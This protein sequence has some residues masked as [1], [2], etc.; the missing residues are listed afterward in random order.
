MGNHYS[1]GMPSHFS[2]IGLAVAD[3]SELASVMDSVIPAAT[4][5]ALTRRGRHLQWIDPAGTSI[6]FHLDR[7]G[8]IEC[9]T[10]FFVPAAGLARWRVRT[11][12]PSPD[13]EC[14]HCSGADCDVL[15]ADGQMVTRTAVQ[16]ACFAPYEEW[17]AHERTYD[18]EV[19]AFAERAAFFASEAEFDAAQAE[20]WGGPKGSEKKPLRFAPVSFLPEGLFGAAKDMDQRAISSFAGR[21]ERAET[22][23]PE[24][25]KAFAHVRISTLP[26][27]VDVVADPAIFEG[28]PEVGRIAWIRA[29]LVGRPVEPAP[30]APPPRSWWGRLT[31]R[32]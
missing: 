29:W 23:K 1:P 26:G 4:E 21:V 32:R 16:W 25:G 24:R 31:G 22:S 7:A 19:V 6:C 17:L 3:S 8:R 20:W 28:A 10:P 2:S 18:L 13:A 15:D 14:R 12:V 9:V 27:A 11:T 30:P 5:V